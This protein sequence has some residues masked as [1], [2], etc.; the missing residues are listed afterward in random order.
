MQLIHS[1][2][3]ELKLELRYI[4]DKHPSPWTYWD[5]YIVDDLAENV[6]D[7]YVEE[8]IGMIIATVFNVVIEDYN[9]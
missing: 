6:F 7:F 1:M 4:I 2:H 5:G 9:L 8:G 3:K